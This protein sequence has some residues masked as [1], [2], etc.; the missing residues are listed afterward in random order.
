MPTS[1]T[2][3]TRRR[4]FSERSS[5]SSRSCRRPR[6]KT[7]ERGFSRLYLESRRLQDDTRGAARPSPGCRGTGRVVLERAGGTVR[8]DHLRADAVRRPR[9]GLGLDRQGAGGRGGVRG[10]GVTALRVERD[11]AIL[12]ITLVRPDR[13]NAFDAVLIAQLTEAFDDVGDA[14]AVVLAG[15][16]TSFSAGADVEWM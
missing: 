2:S 7:R 14:R 15:D 13:R 3:A 1:T 5:R 10:G 11:G 6:R 9:E 4:T 12:R 16:G 8:P